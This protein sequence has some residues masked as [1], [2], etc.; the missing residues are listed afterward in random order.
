M[1]MLDNALASVN[2]TQNNQNTQ[3]AQPTPTTPSSTNGSGDSLLENALA[4]VNADNV[5]APPVNDPRQPG[6]IVNDVGQKVIVPKDGESFAD[7]LKRAVAYHNSLTPE[8]RQAAIDAETKTMPKKAA[9]T[10]G[11][12]ATIGLV[13]PATL[14]ALG[15][16]G[17]A[18]GEA[19]PSVLVHTTEGVK[20][21]GA[22]AAKNP[23]Q[24][25]VLYQVIKDL[26]PGAKKA[27]G[28]VKGMPEP[29]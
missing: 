26:L 24:A 16:G 28:I 20:A 21:I 15:E 22:W 5:Q 25:Y 3:T 10:L 4:S 13:G 17:V 1:S 18:I 14:A 9:Q 6:E 12:A 11:A 23:V 29:E 27:I 7:T 8:Q 2:G 19:I